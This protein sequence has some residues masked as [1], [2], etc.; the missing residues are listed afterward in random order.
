MPAYFDRVVIEAD[1]TLL[2]SLSADE[3]EQL[4]T[5]LNRVIE[6]PAQSDG[7]PQPPDGQKH[8]EPER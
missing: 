4:A 5:L 3:R 8:R 2:R 6:T 1:N 7:P